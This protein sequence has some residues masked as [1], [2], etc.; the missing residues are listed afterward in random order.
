MNVNETS[1]AHLSLVTFLSDMYDP[2]A[3]NN[4][5][6]DDG[7]EDPE[8]T[9]IPESTSGYG[10]STA[11]QL[12]QTSAEPTQEPDPLEFSTEMF[13]VASQT[14]V[15]PSDDE[16][17]QADDSAVTIFPIT[18]EAPTESSG[19]WYQW[20]SIQEKRESARIASTLP[21]AEIQPRN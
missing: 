16:P 20:L 5:F 4:G 18:E 7:V 21:N 10:L 15:T 2:I 12:D 11:D 6:S 14:E 1:C 8:A 9:P 19:T 3:P 13:T 17:T